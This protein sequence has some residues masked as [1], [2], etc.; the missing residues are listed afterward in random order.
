MSNRYLDW[1]RQ[2]EADLHHARHSLELGNYEELLHLRRSSP[3]WYEAI[4]SCL[5]N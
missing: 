3:G 2:A 1:F 5:E 4:L